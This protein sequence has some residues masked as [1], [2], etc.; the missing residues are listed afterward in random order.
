MHEDLLGYLLG[1]L[2][3]L[4]MRRV[5]QRLQDDP[6]ARRQLEEIERSL[7]PLEEG[8]EPPPD[9]PT[10]LISRTLASLPP[11]PAPGGDAAATESG[12]SKS[13]MEAARTSPRVRAWRR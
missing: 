1:A 2:E 10:D 3:P 13:S 12:H 5:A 4:E 11:L 8:F 9:P 6:E 7:R